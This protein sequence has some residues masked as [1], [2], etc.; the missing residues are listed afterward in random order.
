MPQT[1]VSHPPSEAGTTAGAEGRTLELLYKGFIPV[2]RWNSK[3][4]AG[5]GEH[6]SSDT[7]I[8]VAVGNS[9]L[10]PWFAGKIPG[11]G[12]QAS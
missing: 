4:Q 9:R 1:P 10:I 5:R 3:G 11:R 7:H 2:F 12:L 8:P 6:I